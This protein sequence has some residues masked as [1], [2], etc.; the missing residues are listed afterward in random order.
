MKEKVP[1]KNSESPKPS[2]KILTHHR[3]SLVDEKLGKTPSVKTQESLEK[4]KLTETIIIALTSS[5][6]TLTLTILVG[7][8]TYLFGLIP[9]SEGIKWERVN[10][11]CENGRCIVK[12]F[13]YNFEKN[14]RRN[15]K[16]IFSIPPDFHEEFSLIRNPEL[17]PE[18]K[19]PRLM[20]GE[21][22]FI[23]FVPRT[24]LGGEIK[25]ENENNPH[26]S[27]YHINNLAAYKIY[28]LTLEI[29]S[30]SNDTNKILRENQ[31]LFRIT[32]VE[33]LGDYGTR[34]LKLK[35]SIRLYALHIMTVL[36]LLSLS[37]I[38]AIVWKI[39][40]SMREGLK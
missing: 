25:Y 31:F 38:S 22:G 29:A 20:E 35:D 2:K 3:T 8:M 26:Y 10:S 24:N 6:I 39:R 11:Q 12:Y 40:S 4:S 7:G 19:T 21:I 1:N 32:N 34:D 27:S 9:E 28:E 36:I 14:D 17:P 18:E 33:N 37:V 5:I 13:I 16:V 30:K 23:S 15:I